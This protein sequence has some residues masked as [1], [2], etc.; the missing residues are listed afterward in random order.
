MALQP[1]S[2]H[3]VVPVTNEDSSFVPGTTLCADGG[4]SA[5]GWIYKEDT[6]APAR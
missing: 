3:S 1:P 6:G 2:A 4:W 5:M